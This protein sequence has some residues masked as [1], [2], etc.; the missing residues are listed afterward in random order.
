VVNSS[1]IEQQAGSTIKYFPAVRGSFM[2]PS[3]G[4]KKWIHKTYRPTLKSHHRLCN[5]QGT[6]SCK[7]VNPV[8]H[9][10]QSGTHY[11]NWDT[12][13]K[14]GHII[15]SGAH[16]PKW[17]TLSKLGHIIQSGHVIQSGTH[18]PNKIFI[19]YKYFVFFLLLQKIVMND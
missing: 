13:S 18:Y 15:Q 19:K 8:G 11:P 10:I 5:K 1:R 6:L 12:L 4:Q 2:S 14:L 9:I 3:S 17:G 16:Y 7:I